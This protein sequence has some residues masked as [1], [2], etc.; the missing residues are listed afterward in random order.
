MMQ[1]KKR[2][3]RHAIPLGK[4]IAASTIATGIDIAT[5]YIFTS[6][7]GIFYLVSAAAAFLIGTTANYFMNARYTFKKD[8]HH[9]AWVSFTLIGAIGLVITLGAMAIFVEIF[10]IHYLIAR[11]LAAALTLGW[12]YGMNHKFTFKK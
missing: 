6:I 7:L 5:L 8:P 9:K 10:Q 4:Y 3:E 1:H 2:L 12:N 11:L